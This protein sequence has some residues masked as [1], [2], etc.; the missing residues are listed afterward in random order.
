M[1]DHFREITSQSWLSRLKGS[2]QGILFGILLL[3]I[4]VVFLFWNEGRAVTRHRAL[5]EGAGIV[6]SVDPAALDPDNEG[7]LIHFTG[8]AATSEN[9]SDEAFD[10]SVQAIH[11]ERQVEM[12]QWKES[13]ES[14]SE[15]KL[16]GGTETVTEYTYERD[17]SDRLID[18]SRFKIP[19]GHENPDNFPFP[20][21][22]T[23]AREVSVGAIQLSA[24]AVSEIGG[25]QDLE[26][27]PDDLP[28][29]FRWPA[30]SHQ[31]G[32][33]VG[34]NPSSP[35]LGDLRIRFRHVPPQ[36]ISIVARQSG[37]TIQPYR[38]RSGGSIQLV[39]LGRADAESLF[40]GAAR[41]NR[42]MTWLVRL[43][44]VLGIF[45]G[46]TLVLRPLSVMADLI[47]TLGNVVAAGTGYLSFLMAL[48]VAA[49]TIA[50]AWLFYRPL[51]GL[52][53]LLVAALAVAG[54]FR[55][56]RKTRAR[57]TPPPPPAPSR[58]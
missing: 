4:G 44:G 16:G 23:S 56:F 6:V 30:H 42:I 10:V 18:S 9:L 3:V 51:I 54:I 55:L 15:K 29:A 27:S 21:R 33:Y 8:L 14:K 46:L 45:L 41:G 57:P 28:S 38:T 32:L 36:E 11:L 34:E 13:K 49:P 20:G 40:A 31:G 52:L 2:F 25:W 7:K 37:D 5:Q 50:F 26:V 48:L 53:V 47:P 17:W 39:Q 19:E 43:F 35:A 12:F 24:G 58:A 1:P 22:R